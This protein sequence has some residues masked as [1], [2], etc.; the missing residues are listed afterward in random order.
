M[1]TY[2]LYFLNHRHHIKEGHSCR[3]TVGFYMSARSKPLSVA[4][5]GREDLSN[6]DIMPSSL[7]FPIL[8]FGA[9]TQNDKHFHNQL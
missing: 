8:Q 4:A 9:L 7:Q 1:K 2:L 3:Y 5:F 6:A